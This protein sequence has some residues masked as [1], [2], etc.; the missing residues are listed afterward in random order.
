[1]SSIS[2]TFIFQRLYSHI[3]SVSIVTTALMSLL[4]LS[5]SVQAQTTFADDYSPTPMF[6]E[7]TRAS[8]A[9]QSPRLIRTELVTGLTRP[10]GLA[11][12][13]EGRMIITEVPGRMRIVDTDG[14]LSEPL[15]GLPPMRAYSSYGLSD[16]ILDPDFNSNRVIYFT[17][18]L[19]PNGEGGNGTDE[20]HAHYTELYKNWRTLTD[21]E[22]KALPRGSRHVARANL[23]KDY[24]SLEN[25][26]NILEV[27][28][29]RMTF[30]PD[31]TLLITTEGAGGRNEPQDLTHS[32]GKVFRINPDGS[33]PKDNPRFNQAGALPGLFALGFRDPSG[34][35]INPDTGELWTVEH[36]PRGGDEINIIRAGKNYGW[37][38]ISYGRN[39]NK[40]PINEGVPSKKG[41]EQPVY[42]WV[43]SIAPSS[44]NFY[45]A[46]LIPE[47]KGNLFVSAL[48]G[49]HLSRLVI[50]GG[51][52]T[53]EE[54]LFVGFGQRIRYVNQG[55][56]GALYIIIDG[57]GGSLVKITPKPKN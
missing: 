13:P 8:L 16:V 32:S 40:S 55:P 17:Y 29:R 20:E 27:N 41:M 31:G 35:A 38:T 14:G 11:F 12:L 33:I 5:V 15:T 7:Q 42:F 3:R 48:A 30:S 46:D 37:S 53:H 44:L 52:V 49:E 21:E 19:P 39:Y 6:P 23:S 25:V 26:E 51:R 43:P 4:S 9:T 34:A 1:M 57:A 54:R 45:T 28:A 50:D 56:D 2:Y 24:K 36:G 10:W 47:W 18:I 22:K